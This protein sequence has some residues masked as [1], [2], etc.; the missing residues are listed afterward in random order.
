M[1]LRLA[2]LTVTTVCSFLRL[3]STGDR[4]LALARLR[5]EGREL[6]LTAPRLIDMLPPEVPRPPKLM[7]ITEFLRMDLA[8]D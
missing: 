2:Y 7:S 1:L 6:L 5:T 4:A 8:T 3:L